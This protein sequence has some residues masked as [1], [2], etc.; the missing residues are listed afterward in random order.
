MIPCIPVS[1]GGN[2]TSVENDRDYWR[3]HFVGQ[4][5]GAVFGDPDANI[6]S[7]TIEA[8]FEVAEKLIHKLENTPL[9]K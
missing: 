1:D 7:G 6:T 9:T 3:W 8:A 4:M 2:A 5:I